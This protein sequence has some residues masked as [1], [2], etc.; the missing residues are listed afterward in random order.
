MGENIIKKKYTEISIARGIGIIAVVLFHSIATEIPIICYIQKICD[1]FQMPLFFF[2]S[3][4]VALGILNITNMECYVNFIKKKAKRLILPYFI[5]GISLFIPKLLLNNYAVIKVIPNKYIQD[6][7]VYGNNPITFLW[8][9]YVLFIIFVIYSY[10][11]KKNIKLTLIINF[12]LYSFLALTNLNI[13]ILR[14]GQVVYFANYFILGF[15]CR[16]KYD[17]IIIKL[18][19]KQIVT[20]MVCSIVMLLVF[21]ELNY[22]IYIFSFVKGMLGIVAIISISNLILKTTAGKILDII[23]A[24]SYDIY[25]LSWFGQNVPRIVLGQILGLNTGIIFISM[26]VG[27]LSVGIV[28][29]YILRK[30]PLFNKY[31]LGN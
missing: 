19:N 27:G 17:E 21:L 18:K 13:T 25:L 11:I 26:L 15:A 1:S 5:L 3:G 24:Y 22:S 14:I 4:F 9:L 31:V 29:K 23:G 16:L 7:V 30:I 10:L 28:S 8:F 2:L 20:I 6:L 12:A